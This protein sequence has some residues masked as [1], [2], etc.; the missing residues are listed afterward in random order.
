MYVDVYDICLHVAS[1]ASLHVTCLHVT[2]VCM[3]PLALL[4][5]AMHACTCV[6]GRI[7]IEIWIYGTSCAS[8][9]NNMFVCLYAWVY[10]DVCA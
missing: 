4:P 7:Y 3:S 10:I 6:Y 2:Y 1:C 8:L 5:H 9:A